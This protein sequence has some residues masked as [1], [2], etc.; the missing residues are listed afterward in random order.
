VWF[1]DLAPLHDGERV[2]ATCAA[3]LGLREDGDVPL[4]QRLCGHLAARRTLLVLDNCEHVGDTVAALVEALL[5]ST[6]DT[7]VLATS[8]EALGVAGEQIYP[9]RS[10]SLPVTGD[11]PAVR[12]A[13]SVRVF[14]DRAR[15]VLPEFE[16]D[17]DNAAPV[18]EICR[19]LDGIA[20]AIELAA[21]RI[22][23]LSVEQ[24][25]VRLDDRF[26]LLTGGSR[27]LPRQQTLRGVVQWSYEQLSPAEQRMLRQLSV[28]AGGWT[29]QGAADVAQAA[30]EYEALA[31]LGALHDKSLLVV[32]RAP[33]A[34]RVRYR[35]L[36]TVRQYALERLQENG[37]GDA[38]RAT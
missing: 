26:R 19:R 18:A 20:L 6:V 1:V 21:A 4:L 27:A 32:E 5:S 17:A 25:A 37:E 13:E 33:R 15:L 28:F 38:A 10:L 22:A 12:Q 35:M 29:L 14:E 7:A 9:V 30:D 11:L 24:I 23:M 34:E 16:V 3:V 2:T 8:R 36:E 31:L